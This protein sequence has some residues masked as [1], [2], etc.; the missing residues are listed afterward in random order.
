MSLE[1][2]LPRSLTSR[3]LREI[4]GLTKQQI[5]RLA[6]ALNDRA[7]ATW[8]ADGYNELEFGAVL[9]DF[10]ATKEGLAHFQEAAREVEAKVPKWHLTLHSGIFHSVLD[11]FL[12]DPEFRSIFPSGET[13]AIEPGD[14]E[15]IRRFL[16]EGEH[17]PQL[18]EFAWAT[19]LG[20]GSTAFLEESTQSYIDVAAE[21][22]DVLASMGGRGVGAQAEA[23]E[24]GQSENSD[25]GFGEAEAVVTSIREHVRKIRADAP[26]LALLDDLAADVGKLRELAA[27]IKQEREVEILLAKFD[28]V[29]TKFADTIEALEIGGKLETRRG[30]MANRS[31]AAD[32]AETWIDGLAV[33]L[34]LIDLLNR[35]IQELLKNIRTAAADN[36][37]DAIQKHTEAAQ[38]KKTDLEDKVRGLK[39]HLSA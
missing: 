21:L 26:D 22:S 32:E 11:R 25:D 39:A 4:L 18:A 10:I 3:R 27:V 1:G 24:A 13:S 37:L 17:W 35:E 20:S 12:D 14:H 8:Q 38:A 36:D 5:N 34:D 28:D 33:L 2:A 9:A 16:A 23:G 31:Q 15:D 19:A 7:A 29:G 6:K 30:S